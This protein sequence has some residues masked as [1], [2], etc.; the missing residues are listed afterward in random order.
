ML[1][2][3]NW[4]NSKPL[5]ELWSHGWQHGMRSVCVTSRPRST[6]TIDGDLRPWRL[7]RGGMEELLTSLVFWAVRRGQSNA[8]SPSWTCSK[9]ILRLDVFGAWAPDAKKN[10]SE[11]RE[12]ENL[13]QCLEVRTAGDP[14]E[15]DIVYTDLSPRDLSDRLG[16]MG[17]P[18]GRDAIATW[19]RR[20]RN[21]PTSDSQE[22]RRRR[23][24]RSKHAVRADRRTR[25]AVPGGWQPLVLHG[26]EVQGAPRFSVSKRAGSWKFIISSL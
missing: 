9:T 10:A 14:D 8:G 5:L 23:A 6:K 2:L 20:C 12:E 18:V 19:L 1:D 24:S 11:S 26:Y 4:W 25:P 21:P 22:S 7:P 13:I 15:E 17:S 3:V 16:E